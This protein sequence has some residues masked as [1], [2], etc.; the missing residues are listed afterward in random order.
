[1]T[2]F[3]INGG[4]KITESTLSIIE[5]YRLLKQYAHHLKTQLKSYSGEAVSKGGSIERKLRVYNKL[6]KLI[7]YID[8]A[9]KENKE[10]EFDSSSSEQVNTYYSILQHK[11]EKLYATG[12]ENSR[13][14]LTVKTKVKIVEDNFASL[15]E[16]KEVKN[17]IES[18]IESD[19]DVS[20]ATE[21]IR[22][23]GPTPQLNGR[24]LTLFDIQTSPEILS[25]SPVKV[26]KN[27][28]I[29]L[30]IND[31][32][33]HGLDNEF[34]SGV[35]LTPSK[36]IKKRNS[37]DFLGSSSRKLKFDDMDTTP[38]KKLETINQSKRY[39]N[40]TPRYLRTQTVSLHNI[41]EIIIGDEWSDDSVEYI[42]EIDP[43]G[44]IK[45]KSLQKS[46]ELS[47]D[48]E[49]CN[50]LDQL[51]DLTL[52]SS[53]NIEPSPIIKK[54]IGRSLYD[55]HRDLAGLKR[56]LTDLQDL[57]GE[58]GDHYDKNEQDSERHLIDS[59]INDIT[60][61]DKTSVEIVNSAENGVDDL[62]DN[63]DNT[64]ENEITN[65]FDPHYKLRNKMKTVKRSTR[66]SK[67]RTDKILRNDDLELMDIHALAFGNKEI[68]STVGI[69]KDF[70]KDQVD[71]KENED[72]Y[73]EYEDDDEYE[74]EEYTRKDIEELQKGLDSNKSNGKRK[75]KHPLSNN[76][77]RLK[78]NRNRGKFKRRR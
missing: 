17:K 67:L 76:F 40:E 70:E 30:D 37:N 44:K 3:N 54:S 74:E 68:S 13:D 45:F 66:R 11:I 21:D 29:A 52:A 61:K 4:S 32:E 72:Q 50:E 78:I 58:D 7:H 38:V 18:Q 10:K 60:E 71:F 27:I 28:G 6:R 34:D 8:D 36:P 48:D 46:D 20:D 19:N 35:F 26:R 42:D 77:V 55:L 39:I 73:A 43:I 41:D 2:I 12:K 31:N 56:N 75:A 65:V 23:I 16:N 14:D 1:M 63:K 59:T 62:E 15:S 24:V 5:K 49:N 47:S 69:K 9:N 25:I 64:D 22:E 51:P 33:K 53:V 57:M